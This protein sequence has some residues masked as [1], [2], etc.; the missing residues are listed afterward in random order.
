MRLRR[1]LGDENF[2]R[3]VLGIWDS[4]KRP[5]LVPHARWA[6][7]T[8]QEDERPS[9]VAFAVEVS[10]DRAWT[11]IALAGWRADGARHVQVVDVRKGTDWAPDRLAE[12]AEEW[13]P[14]A[15]A[16]NPRGPA[17]SLIADIDAKATKLHKLTGTELAQACSMALDGVEAGTVHHPGQPVLTR[18]AGA[19]GKRRNGETWT[20]RPLDSTDISPFQA[21][22]W[23]LFALASKPRT[24]KPARVLVM[25]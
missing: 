14:V 10:P 11:T 2:R 21:V 15:T 22:T 6:E 23:A 16:I 7:L 24:R 13:K 1:L 12:L 19:L 25:R 17:G 9:P 20:W 18:A 4:D 8:G 3:E 5:S